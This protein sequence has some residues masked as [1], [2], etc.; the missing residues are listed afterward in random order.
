M[1]RTPANR[2]E[3]QTTDGGGG[4]A[5]AQRVEGQRRPNHDKLDPRLA[6]L[7]EYSLAQLTQL[8]RAQDASILD[9]QRER[10]AAEAAAQRQPRY[11]PPT[12]PRDRAQAAPLLT[13]MWYPNGPESEP[14]FSVFIKTSG[15]PAA[16]REVGVRVRSVFGDVVTADVPWAAMARLEALEEVE[17]IELSRPLRRHLDESVALIGA[18]HLHDAT[19]ASGSTAV[20]C[21]LTASGATDCAITGE[22]TVVAV[23]DNGMDFRHPDFYD[24]AAGQVRV[25]ALWDMDAGA[26]PAFPPPGGYTCG[27]GYTRA[28]LDADLNSGT[29]GSVVPYTAAVAAHGTHVAGIAAGN[30]TM[31]PTRKGVAP[32]A[33]LLFVDVQASK[34]L[35]LAE[36]GTL[37]DALAWAF[38]E[39][40][41]SPCV[42]NI[43]LGD[44]LG[45]HDG[46]SLMERAIDDALATPGRAVVVAAGNANE[47]GKHA[48]GA[49]PTTG[50]V[51]VDLTVPNNV[52]LHV[53][54][55]LEIWYD[56]D[57]RFD[58]EVILTPTSGAPVSL[59]PVPAGS[60]M[61]FS[62][63]AGA[64]TLD[65]SIESKVNDPRNGDNVICVMMIPASGSRIT[66]GT[67]TLRLSPSGGSAASVVN[68]SWRGWIDHNTTTNAS[69]GVVWASPTAHAQTLTSPGTARLAITVGCH[70]TTSGQVLEDFSGR[71]PTRDGRVK[72]ELS[73]PGTDIDAPRAGDWSAGT[74]TIWYAR[75]TG[76]SMAAPHVAGSAALLFDGR[77]PG[78]SAADIKQL[79]VDLAN[80]AGFT[81]PHAGH[82]WGRLRVADAICQTLDHPD[83]WAKTHSSDTGLE[84]YSGPAFWK[85]PDIWVRPNRDGGTTHQNPEY[86]Q[87]NHVHVVVRN[88]GVGTA[89]NTEVKLYWA[90]PATNIPYHLWK[91]EGIRVG[92]ADTN[93]QVI[94]E[95]AAGASVQTPVPFSWFPPAPGSNVANDDHFCLLVVLE[96]PADPSGVGVGGWASVRDHNNIALKNVHIVDVV[97]NATAAS[98]GFSARGGRGRTALWLDLARVPAGVTVQL[99][100]PVDALDLRP[101]RKA[102]SAIPKATPV[103]P[104]PSAGPPRFLA[105][106]LPVQLGA[107]RQVLDRD[108]LEAVGRLKGVARL[109][110]FAKRAVFTLDRQAAHLD[111]LLLAPDQAAPARLQLSGLEGFVGRTVEVDVEQ[112]DDGQPV[113]GVTAVFRVPAQAQTR[114]QRPCPTLARSRNSPL[115]RT[116][117]GD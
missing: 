69:S 90:D 92:A 22:G 11:T 45:P 6:T 67:W 40:G 108:V 80:K 78:L 64:P 96:N 57:D 99:T 35:A 17:F 54:E 70:D 37:A 61:V 48:F 23:L 7:M 107:E 73:A 82:G 95:L 26:D 58:V 86:G 63:P 100:L 89:Y 43:S 55:T 2:R 18:D 42:V 15:D 79:L 74:P 91:T 3:E 25:R 71:G 115:L 97:A 21:P 53:A 24:S 20:L 4:S 44:N 66:P 94:P 103:I 112:W 52:P 1:A 27:R 113:G 87:E 46:T 117:R 116:K 110:L 81:V 101:Y 5:E 12:Y 9:V 109:E 104:P 28:Q 31:D 49:V 39:A 62:L 88:R 85:S 14:A 75:K 16:L 106:R 38:D 36:M 60:S 56:G 72:P 34:E 105:R 32:G 77:D 68:G 47:A 98:A 30:G 114:L 83:V 59:G 8:V 50:S 102:L 65:V 29:P 84:P 10:R 13:G 93:V 111:G 19:C 33:D 76:T 41:T 51:D